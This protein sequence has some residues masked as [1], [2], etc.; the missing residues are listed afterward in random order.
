MMPDLPARRVAIVTPS[1]SDLGGTE[2]YVQRLIRIQHNLGLHVRVYTQDPSRVR[3]TC[4]GA[5]VV[6]CGDTLSEGIAPA[7]VVSRAAAVRQLADE[8]AAS[9]DW[10]EFHRLAPFDLMRAL[11]GRLP[12]L[13]FLHTPELTCPALGRHLPRS[14]VSCDRPPGMGCIRVDSFEGCMSRPDGKRFAPHQRLRALARLPLTR[15]TAEAATAFVFNSE[16]LC[17]L[18]L[19][20]VTASPRTLVL[21]PPITG[22]VAD[23][24]RVPDRVLFA[25]RLE[26]HK[27]MLDALEVAAR[28]PGVELR[29]CGEGGARAAAQAIAARRGIRATFTGWLDDAALAREYASAS[30]T[31]VPSRSFEAWGMVGPE[32]IAAGCPVVGFDSGGIREWLA[33]DFGEVVPQGDVHALA[34]AAERQLV[35]MRQ[36]LDTSSWRGRVRARWGEPTYVESYVRVVRAAFAPSIAVNPGHRI[37]SRPAGG[38]RRIAAA[39]AIATQHAR[40]AVAATAQALLFREGPEDPARVAVYRIGTMGDHACAVHALSAIRARHPDAKVSLITD[41]QVGEPWPE[42]LGIAQSLRLEVHTYDTARSLRELVRQL[43]PQAL[44]YL[45]PRPLTL[46]RALR[47]A[48]FFRGAG[49]TSATG[50]SAVDFTPSAA[51]AAQP[52]RTSPPEPLRLLRACGLPERSAIAPP[53]GRLESLPP[54]AVAIAPGGKYPVQHWP[55]ARYIELAVRLSALGYAPVWLGDAQDGA[56]LRALGAKPGTDLTGKLSPP[57]LMA[58]LAQTRAV[59]SND[60]GT[61]H[62]AAW[63]GTPLLVISSARDNAGSWHPWGASAVRVLRRPMTCEGCRLRECDDT[64]CLQWIDV[65]SAWRALQSLLS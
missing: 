31:L 1:V 23:A 20:T 16:A 46:R 28:L 64:S 54:N 49:I 47:D 53:L 35:R 65:E 26:W 9:S 6:G 4:E 18:F 29:V 58:A 32:S 55:E 40:Q 7:G 61:A 50:F 33:P 5:E 42:K 51:R 48:M 38:G 62:L 17:E 22:S 43:A 56:R 11:R 12:T 52:W 27:G 8:I 10:V 60:T 14:G 13:V 3:R 37:A 45:A 59:V 19:R 15:A 44:Y 30:C 63:L 57:E 41:K 39:L 34:Q 24:P 36:G 2:V 25:G 21:H